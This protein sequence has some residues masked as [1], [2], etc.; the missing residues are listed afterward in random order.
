MGSLADHQAAALRRV[1]GLALDDLD[2]LSRS[3]DVQDARSTRRAML[4]DL[5]D[6]THAYQPMAGEVGALYFEDARL[7]AG[8]RGRFVPR[9]VT[10]APPAQLDAMAGYAAGPLFGD[11][12]VAAATKRMGGAL[13]RLIAGALRATVMDA[14]RRD[15]VQ[16]RWFRQARGDACAFCAMNA[17]RGAVYRTE[18]T[19]H[20]RSHDHCHCTVAVLWAGQQRELTV[21]EERFVSDY[22]AARSAAQSAGLSITEGNILP[23]MRAL[24][25][26]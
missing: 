12:D 23:L 5:T 15:P 25:R 17:A 7:A 11:A 9:I 19:S 2:M 26:K 16:A 24:G 20:F 14:T 6:L 10:D 13:S 8:V 18:Q 3:W 22:E 1:T 21:D 4:G